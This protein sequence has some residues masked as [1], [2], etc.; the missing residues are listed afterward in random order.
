M[1]RNSRIE[2]TDHT[3]NPWIGC[4]KVSEGCK[5]CY[6]ERDFTRK[7]RWA[8]TWGPPGASERLRTSEHNWHEPLRWNKIAAEAGRVDFVFCAS[9][10]DV[11]EDNPVLKEWRCDAFDIMRATPNLVWLVLTKRPGNAVEFFSLYPEYLTGNVWLGV[12]IEDKETLWRLGYLA[13][14]NVARTFVSFE[15]LLENLMPDLI[16][17]TKDF[18]PG[19]MI[20]GGESGPDRRR[21]DLDWARNIRDWSLACDIPF[22]FKQADLGDGNGVTKMPA[23]DGV[24]WAERPVIG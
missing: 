11:F 2:W 8:N 21:M 5:Y 19:W 14:V 4:Q 3:F 24:V 13:T 7:E 16:R 17:A 6:A 12:S 23:L 22:F 1:G 18:L 9:L 15:P 20:V 10:C